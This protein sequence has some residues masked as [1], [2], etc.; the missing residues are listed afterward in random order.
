M[1]MRGSSRRNKWFIQFNVER[2]SMQRM[3][4][5][6]RRVNDLAAATAGVCWD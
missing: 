6:G 1:Q 4:G 5:G 2:A 3:V